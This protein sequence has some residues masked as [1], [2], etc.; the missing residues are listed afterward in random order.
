MCTRTHVGMH[1]PC[2]HKW[3]CDKTYKANIHC[4]SNRGVLF[5][6][7][8]QLSV[9]HDTVMTPFV[10]P[11]LTATATT[12]V[13]VSVIVFGFGWKHCSHRGS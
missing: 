8:L 10:Y 2:S 5:L 11:W 7:V 6:I 3:D 13:I 1:T 12:D 4:L 9:H